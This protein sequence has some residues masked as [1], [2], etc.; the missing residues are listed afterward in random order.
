MAYQPNQRQRWRGRLQVWLVTV[1]QDAQLFRGNIQ[2]AVN[3][4]RQTF[5]SSQFYS[6]VRRVATDAVAKWLLKMALNDVAQAANLNVQPE[7]IELIA[8]LA[9]D[10]L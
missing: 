10:F 8:E 6:T 5:P 7:T 9:V 1:V 2:A 3:R 4:N